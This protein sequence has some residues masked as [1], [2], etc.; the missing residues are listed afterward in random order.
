MVGVAY[1][2]WS[3]TTGFNYKALTGKISVFRCFGRRSLMG[4]GRLREVVA[5]G[6]STVSGKSDQWHRITD[7]TKHEGIHTW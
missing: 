5:H 1:R 2:R 4:G 7:R 3:F 6:G